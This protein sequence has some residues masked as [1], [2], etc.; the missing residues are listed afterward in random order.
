MKRTVSMVAVL[1]LAACGGGSSGSN[2]SSSGSSGS[3]PSQVSPANASPSSSGS[4][5]VFT[6]QNGGTLTLNSDNT[7]SFQQGNVGATLSPQLNGSPPAFAPGFGWPG[8]TALYQQSGTSI[9]SFE[10]QRMAG[11]AGL[12]VSDFG[13]WAQINPADGTIASQG[14][15]AGGQSGPV[16]MPTS[17]TAAY[18]GQYIGK[19]GPGRDNMNGGI[20]LQADF[21]HMTMQSQFTSGVLATGETASGPINSNAT[22][23]TSRSRL[24]SGCQVAYTLN[25]QFY[26][27]A[28]N[29][30][31]G[32]FSGSFSP[33]GSFSGVFGAHR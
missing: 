24:C 29:E 10:L 1:A 4:A 8:A 5:Q 27:A 25:G 15:Y 28:A 18:N 11:A 20:N 9:P 30:T 26:G 33:G 3:P 6:L 12:S 23:S 22:Y 19:I 32:S 2:S 7:A 16:Q 31:T 14:F 13:A 17:G 21:G